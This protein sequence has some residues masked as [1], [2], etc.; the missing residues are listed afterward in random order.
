VAGAD[1]T[2]E[3]FGDLRAVAIGFSDFFFPETPIWAIEKTTVSGDFP[4]IP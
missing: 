1:K 2:T 3:H 4:L